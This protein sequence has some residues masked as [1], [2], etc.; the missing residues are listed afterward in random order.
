M[1]NFPN[2]SNKE[3]LIVSEA[4]NSSGNSEEDIDI[5]K[6][7][8]NNIDYFHD[9]NYCNRMFFNWNYRVLQVSTNVI[10]II[11]T[12]TLEIK[13]EALRNT[14]FGNIE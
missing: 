7:S 4:S 5:I 8:K 9:S 14:G 11:I 1:E 6:E 2:H 10:L 12:L 13:R 3:K